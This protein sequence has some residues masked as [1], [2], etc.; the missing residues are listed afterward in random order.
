MFTYESLIKLEWYYNHIQNTGVGISHSN[1]AKRNVVGMQ[2]DNEENVAPEFYSGKGDTKLTPA[3]KAVAHELGADFGQAAIDVKNLIKGKFMRTRLK[4]M[5]GLT[6]DQMDNILLEAGASREWRPRLEDMFGFTFAPVA[7]PDTAGIIMVGPGPKKKAQG[8]QEKL[9]FNTISE[10]LGETGCKRVAIPARVLSA[11]LILPGEVLSDKKF[12]L[13]ATLWMI[14]LFAKTGK[15][16][17]GVQLVRQHAKIFTAHFPNLTPLG[18]GENTRE[19]T[20]EDV[21]Y[22]K[23]TLWTRADVE[24][25][26]HAHG[27]HTVSL[28]PCRHTCVVVRGA[29]LHPAQN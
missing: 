28:F 24:V 18:K 15:T 21:L 2:A 7:V 8:K 25:C 6:G 22:N 23:Q 26:Q 10:E 9:V 20:W 16:N 1:T 3:F 5:F 14:Y 4:H 29:V 17:V 19:R 11:V 13:L 27:V 12:G